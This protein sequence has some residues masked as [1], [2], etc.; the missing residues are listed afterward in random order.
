MSPHGTDF[1]FARAQLIQAMAQESRHSRFASRS[2][3]SWAHLACLLPTRLNNHGLHHGT[4]G[5][6]R[7]WQGSPDGKLRAPARATKLMNNS[8]VES[9]TLGAA[10]MI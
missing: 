4:K 10:E 1:L 3:L 8:Y 9:S 5:V 2:G 7:K 6:T